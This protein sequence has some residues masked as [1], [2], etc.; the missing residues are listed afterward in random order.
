M[1]LIPDDAGSDDDRS[2]RVDGVPKRTLDDTRTEGV[3]GMG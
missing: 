1:V 3:I 2:A